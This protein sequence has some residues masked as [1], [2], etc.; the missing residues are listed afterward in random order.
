MAHKRFT[1]IIPLA[2]DQEF[3]VGIERD[4]ETVL[5][6]GLE[7]SGPNGRQICRDFAQEPHHIS[8]RREG[9]NNQLARLK[10]ARL[11]LLRVGG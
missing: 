10:K 6:T 11:E 2:I 4:L 9:L 1:D 3:V 7:I 5:Y 8:V